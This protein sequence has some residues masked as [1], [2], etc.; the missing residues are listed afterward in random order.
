M[1]KPKPAQSLQDFIK[2]IEP[3]QSCLPLDDLVEAFEKS[4]QNDTTKMPIS[5]LQGVDQMVEINIRRWLRDNEPKDKT[6]PR[7]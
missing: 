3:G 2:D 4:S 6:P 1:N 5:S 7:P